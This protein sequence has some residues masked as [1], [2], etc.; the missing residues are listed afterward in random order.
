MSR[1]KSRI[2]RSVSFTRAAL[3][4][5]RCSPGDACQTLGTLADDCLVRCLTSSPT[6]SPAMLAAMKS[7]AHVENVARSVA[8][9]TWDAAE[10]GSKPVWAHRAPGA[11]MLI[12]SRPIS[13]ARS[14]ATGN[15]PD[16]TQSYSNESASRTIPP[17]A[18]GRPRA[19]G[20][21]AHDEGEPSHASQ[22]P[23][24]RTERVRSDRLASGAK[25][26][27]SPVRGGSRAR[28]R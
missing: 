12:V 13:S 9:H 20:V 23:P 7:G 10:C 2:W 5:K 18:Q 26:Y 16:A 25:R 8:V 21:I 1:P 28:W 4:R 19:W 15:V 17:R 27:R 11:G 6:A 14:E 22:R 3:K 24:E